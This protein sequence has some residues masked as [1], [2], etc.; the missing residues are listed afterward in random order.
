MSVVGTVSPFRFTVGVATLAAGALIAPVAVMPR[1]DVVVRAAELAASPLE[2]YVDL[3]T[4]TVDNLG[5]L[6]GHWVEDPLPVVVQLFANGF[7]YLQATFDAFDATFSSFVDGLI[8]LP[9]QLDTLFDAISSEDIVGAVAEAII[10]VLSAFPVFGLVDR[11]VAIPIEIAGNIVNAATAA[12]HALQVPVGLAALSSLQAAVTEIE[13]IAHDF[14]EDLSAGDLTGALVGLVGAPAQ[15][16][17]AYL[18]SE[19]PGLAG[20][21]MPFQDVN[22][23]GFVDALLNY[24]PRAVAESI[25][26]PHTPI[27]DSP[28][29][30]FGDIDVGDPGALLPD[31]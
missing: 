28:A 12:L 10:I 15:L 29:P 13:T 26:A 16:L 7:G 1:T 4:N 14:I 3:F 20:I 25:G 31:L 22:H 23:T 19:S 21:L 17:N 2:P 11:L 30:D 24:L 9:D 18:N 27:D 5:A 6:A 8:N